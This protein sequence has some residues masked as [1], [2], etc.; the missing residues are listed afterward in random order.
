MVIAAPSAGAD[1]V[2]NG[3]AAGG[4]G[5]THGAD[6]AMAEGMDIEAVTGGAAT[7][8]AGRAATGVA[9]RAA[10]DAA[11]DAEKPKLTRNPPP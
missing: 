8:A 11:G 10:I 6:M 2:D 4:R 5:P 1:P 7:G 9:G 3:A